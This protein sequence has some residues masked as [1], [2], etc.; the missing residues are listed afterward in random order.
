MNYN[1]GNLRELY[2]CTVGYKTEQFIWD[3]ELEYIDDE[4]SLLISEPVQRQRT[5]QYHQG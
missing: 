1:L 3:I 2:G 4:V 5:Q